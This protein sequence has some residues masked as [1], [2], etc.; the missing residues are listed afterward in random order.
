MRP[1]RPEADATGHDVQRCADGQPRVVFLQ[2]SN[3]CH[4]PPVSGPF[5]VDHGVQGTDRLQAHCIRGHAGQSPQ[6]RQ[7][8]GDGG[9]GVGVDRPAPA[10][11]TG[12]HGR[13]QIPD[14][15]APALPHNQP[16]GTHAQGLPD[17]LAQ[18]H[19]SPA[20][21]VPVPGLQGDD[22][23]VDGVQLGCVFDQDESFARLTQ[24]KQR[25]EKRRLARTGGAADQEA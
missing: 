7:P 6:C 3:G 22:M 13:Q 24:A 15:R 11:V 19:H 10:G 16:V 12:V 4:V 18:I 9:R 21:K 2:H 17:E 23:R 8:G 5:H 25:G 14:F 1:R 20:L